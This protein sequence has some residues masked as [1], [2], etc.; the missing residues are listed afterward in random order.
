MLGFQPS[1]CSAD[2]LRQGL[3][4]QYFCVFLNL[5]GLSF[6]A[7]WWN[8][9]HTMGG[10]FGWT[11]LHVLLICCCVISHPKPTDLTQRQLLFSPV[12]SWAWFGWTVFFPFHMVS[13]EVLRAWALELS[14]GHFHSHGWWLM[15]VVCWDIGW[16]WAWGLGRVASSQ[17]G[18]RVLLGSIPV[19]RG[20]RK[21]RQLLWP[22]SATFSL[23][24][25]RESLMRLAYIQREGTNS[26]FWWE[27]CQ[28]TCG[29]VLKWP[30]H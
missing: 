6:G 2:W 28:R 14:E 22:C 17:P 21:L 4:A 23:L 30:H 3:S 1:G 7:G 25:R 13:F 8:E 11:N 27:T 5:R 19:G 20:R 16:E 10:W 29:H 12:C 26:T 15:L 24:D 9:K 18:G